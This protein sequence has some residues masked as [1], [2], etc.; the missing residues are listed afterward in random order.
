MVVPDLRAAVMDYL[1]RT[2]SYDFQNSAGAATPADFL[3]SKLLLR[4]SSS[5]QGNVFNR[6]YSQLKDFHSQRPAA[7]LTTARAKQ[8]AD[9]LEIKDATADAR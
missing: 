4:S 5:T 6:I 1:N 9:A 8:I 2:D 7:T 3:N